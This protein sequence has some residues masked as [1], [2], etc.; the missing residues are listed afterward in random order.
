MRK[1]IKLAFFL[2]LCSSLSSFV[3]VAAEKPQCPTAGK[4]V[5]E[6]FKVCEKKGSNVYYCLQE[7]TYGTQDVWTFILNNFR[8][9]DLD[10]AKKEAK[11]ILSTLHFIGGPTLSYGNEWTCA[12]SV[13]IPREGVT[14]VFASTPYKN[15]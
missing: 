6:G 1:S 15:R 10:D 5:E 3:A 9:Q 7:S 8:A 4:I 13:S 2:A 12:Y 11:Q 14:W